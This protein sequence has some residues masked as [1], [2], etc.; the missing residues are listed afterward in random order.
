MEGGVVLALF[1]DGAVGAVGVQVAHLRY[2]LQL[3]L[4]NHTYI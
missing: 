1:R 4:H 2:V 3:E